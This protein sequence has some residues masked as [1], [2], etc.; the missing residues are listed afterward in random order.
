MTIQKCQFCHKKK[1]N[2]VDIYQ[3]LYL[4]DDCYSK[5]SRMTDDYQCDEKTFN[6][7]SNAILYK[8][9]FNN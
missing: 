2:Q 3:G 5:I 8:T 6:E 9:V 7:V 4:C 1:S